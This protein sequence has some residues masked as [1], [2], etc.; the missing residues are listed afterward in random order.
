VRWL[1]F[2]IYPLLLAIGITGW[3][4][5]DTR[6]SALEERT[7]ANRSV[8]LHLEQAQDIVAIANDL[9]DRIRRVEDR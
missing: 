9:S 6:I 8:E 7:K 4:I 1:T 3:L 5:L 2:I